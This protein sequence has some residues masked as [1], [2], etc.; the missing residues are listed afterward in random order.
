M[1]DSIHIEDLLLR[2]H[3]GITDDERSKRQDVVL[4]LRLDTDCRAAGESDDVSL[5]VNYRTLTKAV[6]QF[7][8]GNSF[9]LVEGLA[10]RIAALCLKH[11]PRIEAVQVRVNKPAALRFARSVGVTIERS[12]A[13]A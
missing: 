2:T 6:I 7:V 1:P 4:N 8:E 9:Q 3:I 11:D 10:E 13:D 12:R 5:T